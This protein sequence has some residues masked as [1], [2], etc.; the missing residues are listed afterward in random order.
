MTGNDEP[1]T[2]GT[3]T[4]NTGINLALLLTIIGAVVGGTKWATEVI[5]RLDS[6]EAAVERSNSDGFGG[7]D[8]ENWIIRFDAAV[9][10][11]T[12]E[13]ERSMYNTNGTAVTLPRFNAPDA[14][15]V[16]SR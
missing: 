14:F 5:V 1:T 10:N 15:P 2:R 3:L 4:L 16:R 12:L 8:M 11:W 9:E 7:A 6:L 13:M